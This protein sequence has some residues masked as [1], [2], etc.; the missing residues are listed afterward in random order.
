MLMMPNNF[1]LFTFDEVFEA[2]PILFAPACSLGRRHV[3]RLIFLHFLVGAQIACGV[4][5][6]RQQRRWRKLSRAKLGVN[7]LSMDP[8]DLRS[9]RFHVLR[10]AGILVRQEVPGRGSVRDE[11][12]LVC[13]ITHNQSLIKRQFCFIHDLSIVFGFVIESV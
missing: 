12:L 5:Q 7:G 3:R 9:L 8:L 10:V 13:P 4:V 6:Q 2:F 11:L 1:L